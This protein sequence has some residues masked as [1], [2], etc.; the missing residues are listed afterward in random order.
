MNVETDLRL[1]RDAALNKRIIAIGECG[2]DKLCNKPLDLQL[3]IFNEQVKISENYRLPLI[4]H[5]VKAF[6]EIIEIRKKV[7]PK[8]KWIIHG[9]TGK[10]QLAQQL[11]K[12]DILLSFGPALIQN[13]PSLNNTFKNI[14]PNCFFLETDDKK[15]PIEKIYSKAAELRNFS[16]EQLKKNQ[17]SI[18]R[19]CFQNFIFTNSK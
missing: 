8:Q 4:I 10:L 1:I 11:I 13:R 16:I 2:L 5:C 18:F 17:S 15:I 19:K 7:T 9:F 3:E 14:S 12:H 6:N